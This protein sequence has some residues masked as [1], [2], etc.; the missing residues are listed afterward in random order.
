VREVDA[1][2]RF[3]GLR[4][5]VGEDQL[6]VPEMRRKRRENILRENVQQL[7]AGLSHDS[8]LCR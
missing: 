1:I 6:D 3:V 5:D 8:L 7:I 2:H 4:D